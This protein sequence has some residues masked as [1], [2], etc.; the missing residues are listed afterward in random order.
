MGGSGR[1]ERIMMEGESS[2]EGAER[3]DSP[4]HLPSNPQ[5]VPASL[6]QQRKHARTHARTQALKH[7]RTRAL[8]RGSLLPTLLSL[9]IRAIYIYN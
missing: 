7:T 3:G 1:E 6:R 8:R 5:L 2:R 9:R 4:I